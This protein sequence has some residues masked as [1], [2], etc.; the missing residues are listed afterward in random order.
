[1]NRF[2]W[3]L[4]VLLFS[5]LSAAQEDISIHTVAEGL[6]YPAGMALL[7][8]G[9]VLI[10]EAGGHGER[11]AG[12]SL[13]RPDGSLGR[14]VSGIP[15]TFSEQ[16]LIS[17][18][19]VAVSPDG[20][21][22]IVAI[23]GSQLYS[24][25][26]ERARTLP[27]QVYS[28]DELER[29]QLDRGNVFFLHPFDIA[30]DRAGAQVVADTAGSGLLAESDDGSLRYIHRF[31]ALDNPR[32]AGGRLEALP[33]GLARGAESFY[34]TLLGGC[35]H[36]LNGG[37]LV[38]ISDEGEQRT[39]VDG[40]NMPIDVA[41]DEAG[42]VWILEHGAVAPGRDCFS[43]LRQEEASGRLSRINQRGVL[44]TVADD[45][46]FPVSVLPL[47]DGSLY[48][49]EAYSGRLLQIQFGAASKPPRRFPPYDKPPASYAEVR[50]LD[51]ALRAIIQAKDLKP[52]PGRE[53]IEAE[54][55][56]TRL[57][58]DLFFDPILS[59]DQ[60][61]SCA[62]CHHPQF[63]MTDGRVLPIGAGGHGLG[64]SRAFRSMIN[65]RSDDGRDHVGVVI[66]PFVDVFIPRNSP[67]IINSALLRE[68]FW[69][70]R[71]EQRPD[72]ETVRTLEDAINDLDLTDALMAQ[73][74]FPITSQ[75]EM[76]G[77]TF[78]DFP[79]MVI[80][81]SLLER[82][83]N[84]EIYAARF[85]AAFDSAHISLRRLAEAVA[86]FERQLIFTAAPWDDY[87]AGDNQALNEQQ[88]RGGLLFFGALNREVNCASCHSGDLFT[89]QDFHNLLAPQLGPGKDNGVHGLD[90]FG[91]ANV[92][93]DYRD[94]YRFKTPSLRNVELTAPYFHSGAYGA[95][96]DVI[97]HHADP[98]R[99]NMVYD[100]AAQLPTAFRDRVLPYDF[101]RQAHSVAFPI[102]AGMPLNE[103]EAADL[104][105]FL[106]ALTD[107][108]ARDLS[109]ITP[110]EVPS[111]LPLDPLPP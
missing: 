63:A 48:V 27:R 16:N 83:R 42:T 90:D 51:A 79:P 23:A 109:H 20:D 24:F 52:Y 6:Y 17:A 108:A 10:A 104:V 33:T 13:L 110:T 80:R 106:M 95:L 55:E 103:A 101:E 78:G 59:G 8:D 111:G 73:V 99:A 64:E 43:E 60:N 102:S 11:S 14:L 44:E 1:M 39:V 38:E 28:A 21:E 40:L 72:S 68:Q 77:L 29:R 5:I 76:A 9:G 107:P 37:E 58:R 66:N 62:T 65:M 98:W 45:L 26:G 50:D 46:H 71:V 74:L 69:D 35:P 81:L 61:I 100:A 97:W 32:Q 18:P 70:G 25:P 57:G 31:D 96:E 88:K 47:P 34:V 2:I 15:S 3:I 19:A 36:V 84:N 92:S 105:A 75:H 67:T 54:S 7:P 4:P 49:T 86:A 91:R 85:A 89:D 82:L 53:I 41:L 12:I 56:L 94:Q 22:V 87:L 30:A 93:F